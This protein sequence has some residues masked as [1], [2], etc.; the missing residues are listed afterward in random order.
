MTIAQEKLKLIAEFEA[1]VARAQLPVPAD[2]RDGL[3]AAFK[4]K[5]EMISVLRSPLPPS[6]DPAGTFGVCAIIGKL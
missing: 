6:A 4:E 1:F 5:R 2:R 3:I